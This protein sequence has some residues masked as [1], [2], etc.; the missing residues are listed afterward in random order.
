MFHRVQGKKLSIS[1]SCLNCKTVVFGELPVSFV[2]ANLFGDEL[3]LSFLVSSNMFNEVS[4]L[5]RGH[6]RR[7]KKTKIDVERL[8]QV[9]LPVR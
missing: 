6:I 4:Q 7:R 5:A 3:T 8:L 2:V 1:A 9:L